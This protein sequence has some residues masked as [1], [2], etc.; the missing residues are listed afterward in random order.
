MPFLVFGCEGKK[1]ERGEIHD[2]GGKVVHGFLNLSPNLRTKPHER[3]ANMA[4]ITRAVVV[5]IV[6]QF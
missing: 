1:R 6:L 3:R 4:T 2:K 5:L